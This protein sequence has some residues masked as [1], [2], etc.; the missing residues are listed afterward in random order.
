M[1]SLI[2][3]HLYRVHKKDKLTRWFVWPHKDKLTHWF[4]WPHTD[5]LTRW[6]V[7]PH[8]DRLTRW[9]VWLHKSARSQHEIILKWLWLYCFVFLYC[10]ALE[11]T[12][13]ALHCMGWKWDWMEL[14]CTAGCIVFWC[15]TVSVLHCVEHYCG[16]ATGNIWA[17]KYYIL[18]IHY[19]PHRLFLC[20]IICGW[21]GL[22]RQLT[23]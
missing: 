15:G 18:P 12:I 14:R 7:W 16:Q 22:N 13:S 19:L 6:F 17:K 10:I 23:N 9:F 3:V 20:L 2:R 8:K 1:T 4:V 11:L 5:K 21:L